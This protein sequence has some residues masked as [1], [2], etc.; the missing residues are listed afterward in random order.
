V[1]A[2]ASAKVAGATASDAAAMYQ[3][4]HAI[5]TDEDAASDVRSTASLYAQQIG[6]GRAATD[7]SYR[8][9]VMSA[10]RNAAAAIN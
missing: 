2:V 8:E 10:W 7:A 9:E 4:C 3:Q 6:S 1:K 5:A